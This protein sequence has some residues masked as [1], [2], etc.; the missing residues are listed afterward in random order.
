MKNSVRK[1][2]LEVNNVKKH[3]YL[4][5]GT[6]LTA[7]DNL[8][9]KI[10]EGEFVSI[11]GPSGCGKSTILKLIA[12]LIGKDGGKLLLDGTEISEPGPERGMVFQS[13]TLFQWLTVRENIEFGLRLIKSQKMPEAEIRNASDYWLNLIGLE[14]FGSFYPASLSGGMQ[15]RVAIARAMIKNPEILLL[16][17]PFG[18]LDAQTRSYM[19]QF[20][21]KLWE[22]THKTI[23]FVTHDI[24]EAIF[25]SD[26]VIVLTSCPAKVNKE[27]VID[28]ERPRDL[29]NMFALPTFI[30]IK[31]EILDLIMKYSKEK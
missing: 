7:L 21:S 24:D 11:V 3:F 25:L 17:E 23:I 22:E 31:R 26:R 20:T 2:V 8:C 16:D 19:Q 28:I 27:I 9:F 14:N 13:Y 6:S 12:G 29:G 4:K 18:A 10:F 30:D 15:Q 5:N 1:T